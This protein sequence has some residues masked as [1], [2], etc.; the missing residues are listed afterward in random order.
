MTEHK[1]RKC[2][3]QLTRTNWPKY[4]EDNYSYICTP[5]CNLQAR[6]SYEGKNGLHQKRLKKY[7]ISIEQYLEM[8]SNQEGKCAICNIKPNIRVLDVD[9]N[10]ATGKVRGLL[11]R[12][13]NMSIGRF[14]DNAMLL[15][16]AASYI[17]RTDGDG[18]I[19]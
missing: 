9:H 14:E 5:C 3:V 4:K 16:N 19:G 13:C 11:C 8:Y 15:R 18:Q 6:K 1:C 2:S 17:E 7:G 10:H 12:R